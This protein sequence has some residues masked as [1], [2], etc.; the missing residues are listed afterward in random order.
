MQASRA[1]VA[2]GMHRSGTSLLSRSLQALGIYTGTDFVEVNR[3]NPTGYWEN[4]FVVELNKRLLQ[5]LRLEWKS[6]SLLDEKAWLTPEIETLRREA[7]AY[8]RTYFGSHPIWSFK[9][10]RTI[11]LL[12]FWRS[13]FAQEKFEDNYIVI[14]RN[15]LSVAASLYQQERMSSIQSHLIWLAHMAP[16]LELLM[17]RPRVFVDY[18]LLMLE[19]RKQ[20]ERIA[21]RLQLTL[22]SENQR[23]I[24]DFAAGFLTAKLR[25]HFFSPDDYDDIPQVG[26]ISREAYRWLRLLATDRMEPDSP[27]FWPTWKEIKTSAERTLVDF[28]NYDM[29]RDAQGNLRCHPHTLFEGSKSELFVVIGFQRT[30]TEILSE[31]LNTHD[32]ITAFQEILLPSPDPNFTIGLHLLTDGVYP[33]DNFLRDISGPKLSLATSSESE[34]L[35]DQYFE[36]LHGRVRQAA[37]NQAKRE[38]RLIGVNIKYSQVGENNPGLWDSNAPPFLLCYLKSRGAKLIHTTRRNVIHCAISSMIAAQRNV[39]HDYEVA[40]IETSYF[41]NIDECLD[42]TRRMLRERDSFNRVAPQFSFATCCYEDLCLDL[43]RTQPD[44]SIPEAP[45]AIHDIAKALG[46]PYRFRYN[47]QLRKSIRVPYSTLISN[48]SDLTDAVERS[49]FSALASTLK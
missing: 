36:Y 8:L 28:S 3:D 20:L 38:C 37:R 31:I 49:E 33:L 45:G 21:D 48:S 11:R 17:G 9:D 43:A 7:G 4:P 23:K 24:D 29:N 34:K 16:Y 22:T 26:P 14:I 40:S 27:R 6:G 19:P 44:T 32:S 18:D 41:I 5:Q 39:W 47:G 30:G 2:L 46:I 10:P 35:L 15:P 13:V 1:I 25:H 42:L 12:P